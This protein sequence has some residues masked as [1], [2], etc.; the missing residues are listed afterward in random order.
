VLALKFAY[1]FIVLSVRM[2]RRPPISQTRCKNSLNSG[3]IRCHPNR[4]RTAHRGL[5]GQS[6]PGGIVALWGEAIRE[7]NHRPRSVEELDQHGPAVG[8][9]DQVSDG[10][11]RQIPTATV[12]PLMRPGLVAGDHGAVAHGFVDCFSALR[13]GLSGSWRWRLRKSSGRTGRLA[14]RPAG[15][16]L[17]SGSRAER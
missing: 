8:R 4:W 11:P 7:P 5:E 14:S 13:R 10:A 6:R 16:S 12:F 17:P 2:V 15:N 1:A 3:R 9:R